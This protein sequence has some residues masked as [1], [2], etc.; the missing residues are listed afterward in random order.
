LHQNTNHLTKKKHGL[1]NRLGCA[2]ENFIVF[3]QSLRSVVDLEKSTI[4]T[5]FFDHQAHPGIKDMVLQR[6]DW[7]EFLTQHFLKIKPKF[8]TEYAKG[9]GPAEAHLNLEK[10]TKKK[11]D[12]TVKYIILFTDGESS[13]RQDELESAQIIS[14]LKKVWQ[15]NGVLGEIFVILIAEL[16]PKLVDTLEYIATGGTGGRLM[17]DSPASVP[18]TPTSNTTTSEHKSSHVMA[19]QDAAKL[20]DVFDGIV[21]SLKE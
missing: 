19:V 16:S 11:D 13:S 8:R 18:S 20:A 2:F 14:N 3:V 6:E 4:S 9:L 1:F 5:F 12:G 17:D 10:N 15:R 21:K 7:Q